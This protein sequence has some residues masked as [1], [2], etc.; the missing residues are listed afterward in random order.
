M[1]LRKF[2]RMRGWEFWRQCQFEPHADRRLSHGKRSARGA[3]LEFQRASTGSL[4]TRRMAQ[5]S[6]AKM[7]RG[8]VASD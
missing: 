1:G 6:I 5:I 2:M 3:N 4:Q 8:A 7:K